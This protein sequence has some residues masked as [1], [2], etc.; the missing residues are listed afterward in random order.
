MDMGLNVWWLAYILLG[1]FA[2]FLAGLLGIGGGGVMVPI[3][4]MIFSA[5]GFLPTEI[6]H[7]ALGT[8]M[9]AI[10]FTALSSIWAH[11]QHGAVRWD[12]VRAM[13]PGVLLGTLIG[14]WLAAQVSGR[15]LAIFFA[16]FFA[17]VAWQMLT[18]TKPSPHREIPSG[19]VQSSVGAGIGLLSCLVA[20][21]GGT[22]TVPFLTWC[23]V[24]VQH[25][26]ATS[27]AVGLPIAAGGA[28]GYLVNG[29]GH[30]GLP[31]HSVGFVY[32]PAVLGIVLASMPVAPFGA[33]AAHRLPVAT[34]KR[35]FGVILLVLAVKMA[36]GV[37]TSVV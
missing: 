16:L 4:V 27:A 11:H 15:S 37:L 36:W 9:A 28:L 25:A 24:K 10:I 30:P 19:L 6:M 14:T 35:V 1:I 26:I 18:N 22:L 20:I 7:L 5:Q 33:K 32:W 23:N 3:L 21:G 2:G 12:V 8:S 34:L 31:E 13:T 17:G 29:W